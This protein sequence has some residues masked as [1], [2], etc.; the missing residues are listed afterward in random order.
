[1]DF[2]LWNYRNVSSEARAPF[3]KYDIVNHL[4]AFSYMQFAIHDKLNYIYF[5]TKKHLKRESNMNLV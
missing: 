2:A 5:H 4:F 1:M 3:E